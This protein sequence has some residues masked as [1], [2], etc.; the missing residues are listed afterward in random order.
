MKVAIWGPNLGQVSE[1]M[2]VHAPN[3]ADTKKGI[4]R[5]AEQPWIIDAANRDKVVMDIYPPGDFGYDPATEL[6]DYAS[7]VKFFPCVRF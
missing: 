7:D 4:Y 5:R 2:H 1:T 6:D 3:C